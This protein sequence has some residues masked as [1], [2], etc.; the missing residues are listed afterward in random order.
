MNANLTQNFGLKY[1]LVVRAVTRVTYAIIDTIGLLGPD[2][3]V[4]LAS[5]NAPLR[6]LNNLNEGS[7]HLIVCDDSKILIVTRLSKKKN[8]NERRYNADN[9]IYCFK[10][11]S[12]QTRL[13]SFGQDVF[14]RSFYKIVLI[15]LLLLFRKSVEAQN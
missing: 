1:F 5:A 11:Q 10:K 13:N 9:E 12:I 8:T 4:A 2:L 6:I 14:S 7:I 3:Q 15:I